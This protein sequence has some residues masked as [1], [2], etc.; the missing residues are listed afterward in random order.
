MPLVTGTLNR[1]TAPRT[2]SRSRPPSSRG[3]T[4][5]ARKPFLVKEHFAPAV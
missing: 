1:K 2:R 5:A 3:D 4:P